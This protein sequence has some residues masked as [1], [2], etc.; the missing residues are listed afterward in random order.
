M[1]G[2]HSM[3]MNQ[4]L[5]PLLAILLSGGTIVGAAASSAQANDPVEPTAGEESENPLDSDPQSGF[6]FSARVTGTSTADADFDDDIG[7]FQYNALIAGLNAKRRIGDS[8]SLNIDLDAGWYSYDITPSASSVAGDAASIGSEFDDVTTL[9]LV[10][11]FSQ[12]FSDTGSW[13]VGGGVLVG[14]ENGADFGDSVD[15]I[16]VGGFRHRINDQLEI[17]LGVYARTRLDDDVLVVPLPQIKYT[18][19]EYWS[20]ESEGAGAKINYHASDDLDYGVYGQYE[21]TTFRLDA[22]HSFAPEGMVTQRSFPIGFYAQYQ[23]RD[24]IHITGRVGGL[25]AMELEILDTNGN[26]V[27]TKDIDTGIFGSLSVSFQF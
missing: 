27:A 12:R 2:L 25:M 17:G 23:P 18:I 14:L 21:S 4:S 24:T 13:F 10:T 11:T 5:C 26:E 20:I 8:S 3:N 16:I 6:V 9:S 7:V 1:K 22:T 19:D 15:G